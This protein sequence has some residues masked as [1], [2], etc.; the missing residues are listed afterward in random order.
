MTPR[1]CLPRLYPPLRRRLN[2]FRD[3]C[4]QSNLLALSDQEKE[5][6][7]T[8]VAIDALNTWSNFARAF[9]LSCVF[10]ATTVNGKRVTY[11]VPSPM[12]APLTPFE[13][14]VHAIVTIKRPHYTN[15][16]TVVMRRDEPSWHM[17]DT[18]PRLSASLSLSIHS[19]IDGAF[20]FGAFSGLRVFRNFFAHRNDDTEARVKRA[21]P[22]FRVPSS[23]RPFEM[24]QFQPPNR[25]PLILD[26]MDELDITGYS[27]C[28]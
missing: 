7:L 10:G 11:T 17:P 14:L 6:V 2:H 23:V 25:P 19:T 12:V 9:Y 3:L 18:L 28:L 15:S 8:F 1:R 13:A 5:R 27:L 20:G 24:L 16:G 21:A 26:W 4:S 22:S